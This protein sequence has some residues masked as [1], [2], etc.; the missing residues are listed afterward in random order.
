MRHRDRTRSAFVEPREGSK[1]AGRY[2]PCYSFVLSA[3]NRS[4]TAQGTVRAP[5]LTL[6]LDTERF[7]NG[8]ELVI[9]WIRNP[10]AV[11]EP[12]E[13]SVFADLLSHIEM[14]RAST[15]SVVG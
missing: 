2:S 15:A 6:S 8:R 1:S 10:L 5:Y 4:A 3:H 13:Q 14:R 7:R 9:L 11:G 12:R